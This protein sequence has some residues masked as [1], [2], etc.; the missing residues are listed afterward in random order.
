[1]A[2]DVEDHK[3]PDLLGGSDLVV[4]AVIEQAHEDAHL[5]KR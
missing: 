5:G 1:M 2:K 4:S 3:T